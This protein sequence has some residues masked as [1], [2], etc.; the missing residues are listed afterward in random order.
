ALMLE[1]NAAL[2]PGD[3]A[4]ILKDSATRLAADP[5]VAG[6]GRVNADGAVGLAESLVF[7]ATSTVTTLL[8]THLADTFVG[9]AGSHTIAGEGGND[10]LDY[11]AAPG[12]VSVNFA[13]GI[14]ANGY[15]GSDSFS[16]IACVEGSSFSDSFIIGA[17]S[18][19]LYGGGGLDT[20]DIAG[21]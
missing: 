1:A 19:T 13:S 6:A 11:S 21:L 4:N 9:G 15:G 10:T 14:A 20:L 2:D 5:D 8:G 18:E 12:A 16:G 3:V 7:T 17:A